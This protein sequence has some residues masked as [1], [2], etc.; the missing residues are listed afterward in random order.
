MWD[1]PGPGPGPGPMSP[2]LADRLLATGPPAKSWI[3]GLIHIAVYKVIEVQDVYWEIESQTSDVG[4]QN[5]LRE[6][7]SP[8]DSDRKES[9]CNAGDRGS[10]PGSGRAT[11]D[12]N[13]YPLQYSCLENS[14][15]RGAWRAT[16]HG[17]A[18]VGHDW[19][20]KSPPP[21]RVLPLVSWREL[22]SSQKFNENSN[23]CLA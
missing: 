21:G 14:K 19:V 12:G 16:V 3:F 9:T 1:L 18:R 10:V 11:A 7:T 22:S 8:D 20:T 4:T 6:K 23:T 17:V 13:G 5:G 15:D 2:A